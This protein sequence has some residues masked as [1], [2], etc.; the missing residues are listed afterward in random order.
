MLSGS[1]QAW[2]PKFCDGPA[3]NS[4]NVVFALFIELFWRPDFGH[5]LPA[6]GLRNQPSVRFWPAVL[7]MRFWLSQHLP[8]KS[9]TAPFL[10]I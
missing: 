8:G 4:E 10:F 2:A 1:R 6:G 3:K 9:A 5:R 7:F